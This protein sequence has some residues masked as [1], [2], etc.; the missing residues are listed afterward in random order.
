MIRSEHGAERRDDS[1]EALVRERQVLGVALDPLDIDAGLG[2]ATSR[3]LEEL[4]RD[5]QA[6]DLRTAACRGNGEGASAPRADVQQVEAGTK[7]DAVE[8]DHADGND[9]PRAGVPVAGRPR[10]PHPLPEV[11][12]NA[13]AATLTDGCG[14]V[15]RG[16]IRGQSP[17]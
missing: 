8:D 10:R 16:R 13:H 4:R 15:T 9:H 17:S 12:R 2:G 5:V 11:R 1:V 3:M 6:D 7:V 14:P